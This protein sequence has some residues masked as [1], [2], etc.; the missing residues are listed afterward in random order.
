MRESP[1]VRWLTHLSGATKIPALP[2]TIVLL[3]CQLQA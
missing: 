3:A 1:A 2:S